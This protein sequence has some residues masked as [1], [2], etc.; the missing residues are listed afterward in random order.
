MKFTTLTLMSLLVAGPSIALA[1]KPAKVLKP[2]AAPKIHVVQHLPPKNDAAEDA[3]QK[4][5]KLANKNARKT[6]TT[7]E[8]TEKAGLKA[9]LSEKHLDKGLTL[10]SAEKTQWKAIEKKYDAQ[11][12]DLR[13]TEKT[14]DNTAKKNNTVD[15]DAA[16]NSQLSSLQAQERTELRNTLTSQQQ[17]IFDAN[18]IKLSASKKH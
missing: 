11:I 10:T 15:N 1:Q 7:E 3:A 2:A 14:A 16:F 18:V 17:A 5:A 6:E 8:K 9:A 4:A 12:R 13:K